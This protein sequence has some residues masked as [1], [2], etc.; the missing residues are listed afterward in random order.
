MTLQ[1]PDDIEAHLRRSLE[2]DGDEAKPFWS[3]FHWLYL[4]L[5]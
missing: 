4:L 5:F 1:D 3:R 2:A